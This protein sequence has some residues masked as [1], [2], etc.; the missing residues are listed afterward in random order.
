MKAILQDIFNYAAA[1]PANVALNTAKFLEN[2]TVDEICDNI[3]VDTV[4]SVLVAFGEDQPKV[5]ELISLLDKDDNSHPD[6]ASVGIYAVIGVPIEHFSDMPFSLYVGMA[7][8]VKGMIGR[9]KTHLSAAA[10]AGDPGKI[11]YQ[12]L[13]RDPKGRRKP[14]AIALLKTNVINLPYLRVC[15]AAFSHLLAA[16]HPTSRTNLARALPSYGIGEFS[17]RIIPSSGTN[18]LKEGACD[19]DGAYETIEERVARRKLLKET[20]M[21]LVSHRA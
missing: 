16:Y 6:A 10:R 9:T 5:Q 8:G 7:W 12:H 4:T 11:L 20:S 2:S 18:C 1:Y 17:D 21:Q 15:E 19:P 14:V 3:F 13:D